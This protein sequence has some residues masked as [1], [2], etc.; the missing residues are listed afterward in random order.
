MSRYQSGIWLSKTVGWDVGQYIPEDCRKL[1][2]DWVTIQKLVE[3]NS[4]EASFYDYSFVIAPMYKA[5][6]GVLWKIAQDFGLVKDDG[7]L[8]NFFDEEN[9]DKHFS[10]FENK[11]KSAQKAREI[12]HELSE[13]KN[14]LK[15]YRHNPAHYGTIFSSESKAEIAS[16]SAL[17]NIGCLID[18]LLKAKLI[19]LPKKPKKKVLL[20]EDIPF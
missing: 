17:H 15:R 4:A 13:L 14:F 2:Y 5:I 11:V 19:S 12:K 9:I 6:E 18:D 3:A 20:E 1:I 10:K 16:K 7:I 8:G